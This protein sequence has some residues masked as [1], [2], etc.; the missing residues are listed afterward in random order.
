MSYQHPELD[1][2]HMADMVEDIRAVSN[3]MGAYTFLN[4]YKLHKR[5][6]QDWS[7]NEPTLTL[8]NGRY[9][10]YEAVKAFFVDYNEAQTRWANEI[11]RKLYPEELGGKSDEEIWAVGSNTVLTFTTPIV[12]IA[13]D[14]KTAKGYWYIF[15]ETTEVYSEGP[16]AAW[17]FGRCAVDFIKENGKWKFW[18]MTVFTD[19]E[20]PL[21]SNWGS[22]EMYPHEGVEIPA[23]TEPGTVYQSYGADYVSTINP[24]YPEPYDTFVNT[25]SY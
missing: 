10:G 23:P 2:L 11:M 16:K 17:K 1:V 18:H 9:V 24:P 14:G 13:F 12:E 7:E 6:F 22:S 15:G 25:F 8:N 21:G 4:C 5:A 20:A 19:I 3:L